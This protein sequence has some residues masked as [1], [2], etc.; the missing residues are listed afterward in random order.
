[1]KSTSEAYEIKVEANTLNLSKKETAKVDF[2]D[3][4]ILPIAGKH[5]PRHLQFYCK[6]TADGEAESCDIRLARISKLPSVSW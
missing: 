3:G 6:T 1:M 5:K 4:V 2:D